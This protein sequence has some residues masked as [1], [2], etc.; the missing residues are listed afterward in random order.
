[1]TKIEE[2]KMAFEMVTPGN[3]KVIEIDT[4]NL[5]GTYE[6][7]SVDRLIE[8]VICHDAYYYNRAPSIERVRF[9]ALAHNLMPQLL[10]AVA[11]LTSGDDPTEADFK[12]KVATLLEKLK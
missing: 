10:E 7:V 1:M 4:D 2:L 8:T 9:L 11:L 12:R 5:D 6:L 3:L